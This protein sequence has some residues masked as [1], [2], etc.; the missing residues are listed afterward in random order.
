MHPLKL[1]SCAAREQT[2]IMAYVYMYIE[3]KFNSK[4]SEICECDLELLNG[5]SNS[6]ESG[7]NCRDC[8]RAKNVFRPW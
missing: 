2:Q 4:A 3:K 8:V 6:I 7:L 1:P 5:R